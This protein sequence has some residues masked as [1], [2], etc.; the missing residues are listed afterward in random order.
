M[1]R[2]WISAKEVLPEEGETVLAT[3]GVIVEMA[4]Y[5][6]TR[7][8]YPKKWWR[9]LSGRAW[10]ESFGSPVK[11]WIPLPKPPKEKRRAKD[12]LRESN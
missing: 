2:R 3:D 7:P 5:S 4:T 8:E 10:K 12:V 9:L 6:C 11:W 1:P